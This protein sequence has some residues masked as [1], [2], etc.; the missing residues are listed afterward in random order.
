MAAPKSQPIPPLHRTITVPWT[1]EASFRRFTDEI[2]TWWPLRTHSVGGEEAQTV[3]LEGR[4]GGRIVEKGR[5]GEEKVWGT[6][7]AWDPPRRVAFTW[8]PG[9][10]PETSQDVEVTF[11]P[12][13]GGTRLDLTHTN[14]ER[15]GKMA[16]AARRGYP[17][18][19]SYV[20]RLWAGRRRGAFMRTVEVMMWVLGPLQRR[21]ARKLS[22]PSGG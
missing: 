2:A 12:E 10:S 11:T 8:H 14:W 9:Q 18:G 21:A 3:V 16:R 5:A 6:V 4:V 17:I 13:A 22:A 19:W 20:L 1:P 15:L 7:T